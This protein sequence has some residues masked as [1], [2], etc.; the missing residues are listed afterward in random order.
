MLPITEDQ[1][2]TLRRW[3]ATVG[4]HPRK[5]DKAFLQID[6]GLTEE[7]IDFW[8]MSCGLADDAGSQRS[9]STSSTL[10]DAAPDLQVRGFG[11]PDRDLSSRYGHVFGDLQFDLQGEAFVDYSAPV[12]QVLA[13]N[14][15]PIESPQ[16][17]FPNPMPVSAFPQPRFWDSEA[18]S[19]RG[20]LRSSGATF[21]ET[22][23]VLSSPSTNWKYGSDR[24][25]A[26][27]HGS[28]LRTWDTSST[29]YSM[30]EFCP[31]PL[32]ESNFGSPEDTSVEPSKLAHCHSRQHS[33]SSNPPSSD[34]YHPHRSPSISIPPTKKSPTLSP[35]TKI[36]PDTPLKSDKTQ[37]KYACTVCHLHFT[38]KGD[39]ERHE[40]TQCEPQEYWTCMLGDPATPTENGWICTFCDAILPDRNASM[41]HLLKDHHINVCRLIHIAEHYE[42]E[43][44]SISQWSHSNVVKGLLKQ[45]QGFDVSKAWKDIV[46]RAP[47]SDRLLEWSKEDAA[48]LQGK[49]EAH[50]GTPQQLAAEARR[51]A[52]QSPQQLQDSAWSDG[53]SRA[54]TL[55]SVMLVDGARNAWLQPS[56]GDINMCA[57]ESVIRQDSG[58]INGFI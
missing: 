18:S 8:F 46:G 43:N 53:D 33:Q 16:E 47:R 12:T 11:Q 28:S 44:L 51:L 6:K 4:K 26:F 45:F 24:S 50:Q 22:E 30:N 57:F 17:A 41:E 25:S 7:Q 27:S 52:I 48:M 15:T 58:K 14:W 35:T 19:Q 37:G 13:Q 36:T 34:H 29:M 1:E 2:W 54:A 31:E 23:S 42:K 3:A 56:S 49:L 32:P 21:A 55:A 38:R 39:W 40:G 5:R 10:D 9:S 20:L